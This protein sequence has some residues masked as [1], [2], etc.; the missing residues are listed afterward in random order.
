[1]V[2]QNCAPSLLSNL[3]CPVLGAPYYFLLVRLDWNLKEATR[4]ILKWEPLGKEKH[5]E[6]SP[7]YFKLL[8]IFT[9]ICN[10][11]MWFS[12]SLLN[13]RESESKENAVIIMKIPV[14]ILDGVTLQVIFDPSNIHKTNCLPRMCC[15]IIITL[16]R[17]FPIQPSL[18]L[19]SVVLIIRHRNTQTHTPLM[20][21]LVSTCGNEKYKFLRIFRNV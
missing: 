15:C 4:T 11:T 10:F 12:K 21:S 19:H 8:L 16:I 9:R 18:Y 13:E 1:M 6:L 7:S 20:I 5:K 3:F 14:E 17:S 2:I